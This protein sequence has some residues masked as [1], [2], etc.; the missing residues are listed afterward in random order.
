MDI[1]SPGKAPI[2]VDIV[3]VHGLRG[4]KISTWTAANDIFWPS[5]LLPTDLPNAR[6][7][8]WDYDSAV[9]HL[10]NFSSQNSIF[11]HADNLLMDLSTERKAKDQVIKYHYRLCPS[12]DHILETT[13]YY[14]CRAQPGRP[15]H[16]TGTSES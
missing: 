14:I 2:K 16:Q 7:M 13:T 1:V 9:T 8:T 10:N 5:H 15:S 6:I 4:D 11:G 12:T 3:F